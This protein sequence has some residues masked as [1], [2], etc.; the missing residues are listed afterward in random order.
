M[1]F[2]YNRHSWHPTGC[3]F[4]TTYNLNSHPTTCFSIA[5]VERVSPKKIFGK[6]VLTRC[7]PENFGKQKNPTISTSF[8]ARPIY[9]SQGQILLSS[10]VCKDF[11]WYKSG[12][13]E[14]LRTFLGSILLPVLLGRLMGVCITYWTASGDVS[15]KAQRLLWDLRLEL[16]LGQWFEITGF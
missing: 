8:D 14:N 11:V 5:L 7:N 6:T 9:R 12:A 16:C 1:N 10:R 13:F 3:Y 15:E 2:I 4:S